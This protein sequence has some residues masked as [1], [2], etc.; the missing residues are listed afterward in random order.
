MKSTKIFLL[1]LSQV[2][3]NQYIFTQSNSVFSEVK[4][5]EDEKQRKEKELHIKKME[6][7]V[8]YFEQHPMCFRNKGEVEGVESDILK[9][10]VTWARNKKNMEISLQFEPYFN[11]EEFLGAVSSGGPMVIG[12]GTV[13]IKDERK[14]DLIFSPPYMNNVSV[15]ITQGIVPSISSKEES[16]NIL[17]GMKGIVTK[18]AVHMGYMEDIKKTYLPGM[19]IEYAKKPIEVI[20]K[21]SSDARYFGY[22]DIVTFWQY[23][24][25]S[26]KY[27]KIQRVLNIKE[28][29]FGFIMP[30]QS[31][32]SV[33]M[34]EFFDSG[35]G[36]TS[37]K[38]YQAILEKHLGYEVIS[39]V[40]IRQ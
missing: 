36:F 7:T 30:K 35:F 33:L 40:E 13:A 18:N 14:K 31:E 21:I 16:V 26:D 10:F 3:V 4:K 12:A 22:V 27:I 17:K 19:T 29:K 20:E 23:L 5:E 1:I 2:F 11:F 32:F 9:E 24:K 8:F 25:Q 38:T 28:E 6:G 34:Q 37:T 15:F 39:T